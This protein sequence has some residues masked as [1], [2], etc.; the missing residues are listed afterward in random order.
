MSLFCGSTSSQM[1]SFQ[2][3]GQPSMLVKISA[4]LFFTIISALKLSTMSISYTS[5][6]NPPLISI[7]SK[8]KLNWNSSGRLFILIKTAPSSPTI[9]NESLSFAIVYFILV[10]KKNFDFRASNVFDFKMENSLLFL[11]ASSVDK[12]FS[13]ATLTHPY[14]YLSQNPSSIEAPEYSRE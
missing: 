2:S 6:K 14:Q 3:C 11:I 7:K 5:S 13:G 1:Y 10:F 12:K 8:M 4:V 9:F